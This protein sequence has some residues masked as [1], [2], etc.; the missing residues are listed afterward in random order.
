MELFGYYT[1]FWD[2]NA[3]QIANHAE[4]VRIS[5]IASFA[6]PYITFSEQWCQQERRTPKTIEMLHLGMVFF[7]LTRETLTAMPV[8][9]L[10]ETETMD[11]LNEYRIAFEYFLQRLPGISLRFDTRCTDE[12]KQNG[13]RSSIRFATDSDFHTSL[14]LTMR[15]R[16]CFTH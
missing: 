4:T 13:F 2:G 6:P 8:F 3:T 14:S 10:Q 12:M 1:D 16:R 5:R 9:R 7:A 11:W 15:K